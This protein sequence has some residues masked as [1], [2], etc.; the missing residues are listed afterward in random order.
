MPRSNTSSALLHLHHPLL[1]ILL[2][3]LILPWNIIALAEQEEHSDEKNHVLVLD[4]TNFSKVV[5]EHPFI[6]VEFY[7]PW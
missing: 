5:A 2:V 4:S 1:F 6:V 7:A 3:T